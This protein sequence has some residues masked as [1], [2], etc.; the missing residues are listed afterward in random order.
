MIKIMVISKRIPVYHTYLTGV[1]SGRA[2]VSF[3][4]KNK[5]YYVNFFNDPVIFRKYS[6]I[7]FNFILKL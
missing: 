5:N 6:N 4:D 3:I 2:P 7:S 1:P